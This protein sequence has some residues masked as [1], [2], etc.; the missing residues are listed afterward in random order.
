MGPNPVISAEYDPAALIRAI[1]RFPEARV[2]VA[3]DVMMDR[4]VW[5]RVDR[6]SPEAPV[7][8]VNVVEETYMLGGAANVLRNIVTLG[9][10]AVLMGVVGDDRMGLRVKEFVEDLGADSS[11][12]VIDP[13]RPTSIKTRVVAH[14]QQV[15]RFDRESRKPIGP[16]VVDRMIDFTRQRADTLSGVIISDYGKGVISTG[17]IEGLRRIIMSGGK[18]V[19]VDPKVEN[20]D[21]YRGVSVI[22]PNHYEAA[23]GSKIDIKNEDDLLLAGQRLLDNLEC[24]VVLITRGEKG[25]TLF[26]YDEPPVHIPTVAREVFDVTGAGDTVIATM[27]LGLAVGL[28]AVEAAVLANFAAGVVVGEVG[29]SAVNAERLKDTVENGR[30]DRRGKP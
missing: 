16:E 1:D 30:P 27:T 18:V 7:P 23:A 20:F 21:F 29:T 11:G 13:D 3:G 2:L 12:L 10:Q 17:L 9:G 4:F 6:I 24:G 25:M 28:S 15:V 26:R 14:S 22:T 19:S 5:G 8:V